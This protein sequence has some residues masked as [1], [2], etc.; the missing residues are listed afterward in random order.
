MVLVPTT[1]D[2]YYTKNYGTAT[3]TES[4]TLILV[5]K[6]NFNRAQQMVAIR[7]VMWFCI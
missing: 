5:D 6:D 1:P 3:F 4:E 7:Y 2:V